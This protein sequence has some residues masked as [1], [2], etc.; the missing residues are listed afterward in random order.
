MK[1]K[2]DKNVSVQLSLYS[3][4]DEIS[5]IEHL[6]K[7]RD[8]PQFLAEQIDDLKTLTQFAASQYTNKARTILNLSK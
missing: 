3:I 1:G 7:Y 8:N 4:F 5:S 2:K 6:L